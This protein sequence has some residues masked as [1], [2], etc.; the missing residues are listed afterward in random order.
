MIIVIAGALG[1]TVWVLQQQGRMTAEVNQKTNEY[2]NRLD[3]NIEISQVKINN[4]KFNLTLYNDG[5]SAAQLKTIYIVNETAVP[6]QQYRYDIDYLVD[7]RAVV[8]NVGQALALTAR[9]TT[10]YSIRVITESGSAAS[11]VYIP[12]SLTPLP[13]S[14]SVIP[15]TVTTGENVTLLY[16]ITNNLTGSEPLTVYPT[17]SKSVSCPGGLTCTATKVSSGPTKV[18]IEKGQ[19]AVVKE[20]YKID[21]PADMRVTFNASFTGAKSGNFVTAKT[22][23]I[24]VAYTQGLSSGIAT[25]PA[26]FLIVP[27]PFGDSG[28]ASD[29]TGCQG[30]AGQEGL[31]GVVVVNPTTSSMKVSR[32]LITVF[33]ASHTGDEVMITNCGRTQIFPNV[34]AEWTCPHNNQ[35]QW[36]NLGIPQTLVPGETKSFL[37]R[38]KPSDLSISEEPGATVVATVYTDIGIFTKAG[39]TTAMGNANNPLGAVYL[40]N[41][42]GTGTGATG[43][44]NNANMLGHKSNIPPN[45]YQSFHVAMADLDTNS[46]T[47]IN[48]GMKLVINVPPGFNN[49]AVTS[50]VGF[51]TTSVTVRADGVTQI[52][53]T[54]ASSSSGRLGNSSPEAEVINFHATTPSPA[55][56]TT[57]IMFAFIDGLTNGSPQIS[58]GALAELALEIDVP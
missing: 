3:E 10:S 36:K 58:A 31:W 24:V 42:N 6:K 7:G 50:S 46:G 56:D 40:T 25:Q 22:T 17:I 44:L 47:Y 35:I 2:L 13:L 51:S 43:A 57:Y 29:D 14:L 33:T 34:L 38:V 26:I 30:C 18:V 49:V 19:F 28:T 12:N 21:G 15:S 11:A 5:G 16:T 32:V 1:T 54:T 9:N 52:V 27:G 45:S 23:V 4:N 41:T 53:G 48:G 55:I 8:N 37:V 20:Q 39:F